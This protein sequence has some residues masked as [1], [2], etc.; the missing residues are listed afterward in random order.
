M[1]L[2][3]RMILLM[4]A[5]NWFEQLLAEYVPESDRNPSDSIDIMY[6]VQYEG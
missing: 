1:V 3:Q 5:K 6:G 4:E 2:F